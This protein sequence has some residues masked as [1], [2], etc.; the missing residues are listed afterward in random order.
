[1]VACCS[2]KKTMTLRAMIATVSTGKRRVG[3]SSLIGIKAG[4]A[5]A[6]VRSGCRLREGLLGVVARPHQRPRGDRVEAHLVRLALELGE[7]VGVPV[8]H[9]REMIDRGSQVL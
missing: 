8:A 2:V 3:M 7:L 6:R 1:M 5:S 4:Q 9:H